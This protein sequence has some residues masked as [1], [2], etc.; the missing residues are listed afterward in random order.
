MK[1][2]VVVVM[3]VV[4]MVVVVEY[5]LWCSGVS[6]VMVT[7]FVRMEVVIIERVQ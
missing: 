1:V 4:E 7:P 3:L 5:W 6:A 2:M